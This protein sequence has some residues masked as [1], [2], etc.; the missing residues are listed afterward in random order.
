VTDYDDRR[1][2][3]QASF[4]Q[5]NGQQPGDPA[6]LAEAMVQ[7]ANEAVPP[8]RFVA[9]SIAVD[10][11]DAKLAST[12]AELDHWRLLSVGTDGHYGV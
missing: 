10:A 9:G 8:L 6:K 11:A 5:R 1:A 4:E 3:I 12:R 2:R 7:L